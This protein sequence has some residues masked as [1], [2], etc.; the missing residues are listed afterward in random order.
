M[1]VNSLTSHKSVT[2]LH[3][4]KILKNCGGNRKVCLDSN[5]NNGF[6]RSTRCMTRETFAVV[7]SALKGYPENK[8]LF[9]LNPPSHI[10]KPASKIF[11][12]K[13]GSGPSS[14]SVQTSLDMFG[15]IR[16]KRPSPYSHSSICHMAVQCRKKS[17]SGETVEDIIEQELDFIKKDAVTM[18]ILKLTNDN[19]SVYELGD[20]VEKMIN[21]SRGRVC[22]TNTNSD[23]DVFPTDEIPERAQPQHTAT[24]KERKRVATFLDSTESDTS[25]KQDSEMSRKMSEKRREA[26]DPEDQSRDPGPLTIKIKNNKYGDVFSIDSSD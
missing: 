14:S 22:N 2:R 6:K 11:V 24:S 9:K 19:L 16:R 25:D 15:S 7:D 20:A 23:S 13:K 26:L 5:V 21:D 1:K 18:D 8:Q 12:E 4:Q 3:L 10:P 17:S